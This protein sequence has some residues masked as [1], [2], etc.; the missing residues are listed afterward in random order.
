[1]TVTVMVTVMVTVTMTMT[2]MVIQNRSIAKNLHF[3]IK[4]TLFLNPSVMLFSAGR[5]DRETK[6]EAIVAYLAL[7]KGGYRVHYA[8]VAT[9]QGWIW[10]RP[11]PHPRALRQP[12]QL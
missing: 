7:S 3:P 11:S 9:I 4:L 5:A 8:R 10:V 1:M 6:G 12:L 2:V